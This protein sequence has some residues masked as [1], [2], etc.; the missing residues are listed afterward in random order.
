M[1]AKLPLLLLH[2]LLSW[3]TQC[4]AHAPSCAFNGE[5]YMDEKVWSPN[6]G[7]QEDASG[8]QRACLADVGCSYWT[9][10]N[11]T[12]TCWLMGPHATLGTI[13]DSTATSG[14]KSCNAKE[15]PQVQ[16]SAAP[17][18]AITAGQNATLQDAL[19]EIQ[20][21][22]TLAMQRLDDQVAP[23]APL[24]SALERLQLMTPE[25][26]RSFAGLPW[27]VAVAALLSAAA[28][29]TAVLWFYRNQS[30]G[31]D[32]PVDASWDEESL[33]EL[34]RLQPTGPSAPRPSGPRVHALDYVMRAGHGQPILMASPSGPGEQ[35]NANFV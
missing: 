17:A 35:V 6:G 29:G 18:T 10:Y 20:H 28:I 22:G 19:R 2:L 33:V 1:A 26:T 16:R 27:F 4:A 11:K 32:Q 5:H 31:S 8:C 14:P 7:L 34:P 25:A 15:V 24:R 30:D 21:S 23:M 3:P 9:F 12:F 13:P